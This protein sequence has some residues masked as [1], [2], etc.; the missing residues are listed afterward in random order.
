MAF[1]AQPIALS[2]RP[3]QVTH[4]CFPADGV[5][6][7][8]NVE[9]GSDATAFPYAALYSKLSNT[10]QGRPSRL[11]YDAQA[12][13][14]EPTVVASTL[15]TL[16]APSVRMALLKA[17]NSRENSYFAKYTDPKGLADQIITFY[18]GGMPNTKPQ[19][20]AILQGLAQSQADALHSA[21]VADNRAF[22]ATVPGSGVVKQTRSDV[23]A[24]TR[25][26]S[27]ELGHQSDQ[28]I[29]NLAGQ[30]V[31]SEPTE[32]M[33]KLSITSGDIATLGYTEEMGL[34]KTSSHSFSRESQHISNTDYSY[35]MPDIEREAQNQRAQISLIDQQF[36]QFMFGQNLPYLTSVF[37]NELQ[38]I[39]CDVYQLQ[40]AFLNT[41]LMSPISGTVTRIYKNPGDAV[42]AGEPV[43]RVEDNSTILVVASVKANLAIELHQPA[44]IQ[45]NAL[46]ESAT[47]P[48]ISQ[49]LPGTIVSARGGRSD[50]L[51]EVVIKCKNP[52]S[53]GK[54]IFPLGFHFD[55]DNVT[56]TIG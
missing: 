3:F 10:V 55:Y 50:D 14:N 44:L 40:V 53:A 54:P 16:R 32:P 24:T 45:T 33:T 37:A 31:F 2:V 56:V 11:N 49:A 29:G 35:R 7:T 48:P 36:A 39:D 21:Y 52:L 23:H 38:S 1:A 8:L 20:L 30:Q 26:H 9:L 22:S 47:K 19:R 46:F 6:E 43:I 51:W 5:L 25:E 4:L 41:I 13:Q 15:A 12:I 28:V 42:R 27:H 34:D 17:I 18:S